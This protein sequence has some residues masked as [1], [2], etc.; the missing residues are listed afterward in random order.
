MICRSLTLKRNEMLNLER[1]INQTNKFCL[2]FPKNTTKC[3]VKNDTP[4]SLTQRVNVRS[5]SVDEAI[6]YMLILLSTILPR[7]ENC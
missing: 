6:L 7:N 3:A 2:D 1:E 4:L 5:C